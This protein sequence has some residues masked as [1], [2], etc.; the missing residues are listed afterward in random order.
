MTNYELEKWIWTEKDFNQM[1]W[2]DATV[3][4]LRLNKHLELD[5]DYIFHW[6]EPDIEGFHF[7]FWVAPATLVFETPTDFSFELTQSLDGNWLEIQDI[8][9]NEGN[10]TRQ[11]KII[12]TQGSI[13]FKSNS[14]KQFIRKQPSL[15][16]GQSI[17]YDERGGPSFELVTGEK[18]I[19][20]QNHHIE[21]R[22]QKEFAAY[23]LAKIK[24]GLKGELDKLN[25]KHDAGQLQTKDFLIEKRELKEKIDLLTVQLRGTQYEEM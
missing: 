17:P 3:Y 20:E 7:T 14:Y 10:G 18:L 8:E 24:F 25:A 11:W 2:H 22:R 13:S 21:E 12:T 1:G 16:L 23:E 19:E 6:N 9:M 5:I 4:G 15:Q